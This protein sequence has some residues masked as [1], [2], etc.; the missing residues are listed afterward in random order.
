ML[1]R[2]V[3][4]KV[5]AMVIALFGMVALPVA[6]ASALAVPPKPTDIPIVD[7]TNTLTADQK[8]SIAAKI[9]EERQATGN[10]IA[11][12]I[13]PSLE[14]DALENYSLDVARE[15]GIGQKERS[16]GVLLLVAKEDRKLRIEVG[17]GLEGS[18]PDITANRIIRDRIRP[19][20]QQNDYYRGVDA[21]VDQRRESAID[22]SRLPVGVGSIVE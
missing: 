20:F 10:Q 4:I 19:A 7:Q 17:Y 14:G 2:H 18:L 1:L 11:I 22:G 5:I 3:R 9:A 21:G 13:I 6:S 12:L 16:S 15:W 8:T